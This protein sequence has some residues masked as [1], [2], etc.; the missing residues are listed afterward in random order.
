MFPLRKK[1]LYK[2]KYDEK[3]TIK[4]MCKKNNSVD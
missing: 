1:G 4:T 3:G 2:R